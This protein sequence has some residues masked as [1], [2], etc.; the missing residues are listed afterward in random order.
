MMLLL[1]TLVLVLTSR[2]YARPVST[3]ILDPV[4]VLERDIHHTRPGLEVDTRIAHL[5][6]AVK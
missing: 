4:A 3:Y 6:H 2:V 5:A 1:S